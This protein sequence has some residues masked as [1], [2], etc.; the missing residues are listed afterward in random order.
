MGIQHLLEWVALRTRGR[1][2]RSGSRLYRRQQSSLAASLRA[3]RAF[4]EPLEDRCVLAAI[5]ETPLIN[6]SIDISGGD[7]VIADL[8][9]IDSTLTIQSDT[10]NNVFVISDPN[11]LLGFATSIEGAT[12]HGSGA[13]TV[14]F[15]A[16]TGSQIIVDTLD[17]NDTLTVDF[18][19]GHFSPDITY[20]G[21]D[22][23]DPHG[24]D[25][26]LQGGGTFALA[27]Y[28]FANAT[29]GSIDISGNATITYSG[30]EQPI[31]STIDATDITLNYSAAAETITVVEA[32]HLTF[33]E[34]KDDVRFG[35]RSVTTSPDGKH[36]YIASLSSNAVSILSRDAVTGRLTFVEAIQDGD[37]GIDGLED[38]R[39]VT[40]SP[41]GNHV[42]FVSDYFRS[43]DDGAVTVFS[44]DAV[45][46]RLTFV[47]TIKDSDA[48]IDG[49]GGAYDVT[50]SPDGSHVY[51]AS[52]SDAAVVVFSRD[53]ETGRLAFVETIQDGDTGLDR[54][55]GAR[56]IT[57]SPDGKHVYLVSQF[58]GA[59]AVFS[60][61]AVTGRLTFVEAIK[62][63]DAGID[64][65]DGAKDVTSSPDG[66]HVYVASGF[67]DNAVS[68]FSRDAVTGRLEFVETIK[69]IERGID[70]LDGAYDVATSPDGKH[71]YIA[72]LS[73]DAMAVFSRDA[74]TGR[75]TLVE[76]I[77]ASDAGIDELDG[78]TTSPDG[79]DVYITSFS[80]AVAVFSRN[81]IVRQ[82]T[83]VTSTAGESLTF[84]NPDD[85]L[86][87][88]AG[89]TG[90]DTIHINS[91]DADHP[92]KIVVNGQGGD[93]QLTIDFSVGNFSSPI[94]YH[95]GDTA[96]SSGDNLVLQGG[97]T[98]ASAEYN[99]AN[100]T[101]GN[102]DIAGNAT[103]TYTGLEQPITSTINAT[104]VTLNYSAED[105]TI[106]VTDASV[107]GT[108]RLTFVETIKDSDAGIDGLGEAG[109]VTTSPDGKHVYI[110]SSSDN[111]VTVFSSDARTGL[112]TFVE[113]IK[114]SDAG[115][116][117]LNKA[118]GVA[119]SPDGKHVYIATNSENAVVVFGRDA[120]T[121]RLTFVE[122][123][124]DSEVGNGGGGN[125]GLTT[126]LDGKYVYVTS[127]LDET[128]A[129]FSRDAAT[130]RLTL[131]E[132]IKDG[133]AG[134]DGLDGAHGITTSPDEN[135]VYIA[136]GIADNA[137]TVF[138]RDAVT[139]RLTFVETIKDSDAGIDGL[140]HASGVT[141]SPD[142]KH[143][144]IASRFD[145]AVA[146]FSR[147]AGT[148]RLTFVET[149]RGIDGLDG[150]RGITAS[151]DGNHVYIASLSDNA[152]A[153]FS[154]D[155]A[156]GRLTLVE[157]IQDSDAG[158]DGLD[159]ARAITTSP[160][161]NL[162]YIASSTDGAVA[163]FRRDDGARNTVT[164]TAGQSVTSAN[165][166]GSL[167]INAGS[168]NDT[169][170]LTGIGHDLDL[171]QVADASLQGF[172][173]IDITGDGDNTLT[174]DASEVI[175]LSPTTD[176]LRVRHDVGDVVNYRGDW[177]V[178]LPQ[179]IDTQYVHILIQDGATIEVANT[180]A[181]QNPLLSLD[182]N[183]DRSVSPVDAL[184][185]INRLNTVGPAE[186]LT[187]T[188]IGN[189]TEFFYLDTNG[190]RFL[191]PIDVIRIVNFLNDTVSNQEGEYAVSQVASR[192]FDGTS[193]LSD[194]PVAGQ[195]D[196]SPTLHCSAKL[197]VGP[198]TAKEYLQPAQSR[199]KR[200][201]TGSEDEDL[202]IAVDAFFGDF[203]F[204]TL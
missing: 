56:G 50:T 53:T 55:S 186:L 102:I 46:G 6:S 51:I 82:Q 94:E 173:A 62:D 104:D 181:F 21:G 78:V 118:S 164:S 133:D 97:G 23:G 153:V 158:I 203:N 12:G 152:I 130:G 113:T 69:D 144:Y 185:V 131:V 88:N 43:R 30:L 66:K 44:R 161:G 86:T 127:W 116:D 92:D 157:T 191:A 103:I 141:T 166:S 67:P 114:D 154:R 84:V 33:V 59:V 19:L 112:L 145:D 95:G 167:T 15:A 200:L 4:F 9:G 199:M 5:V 57:T 119:T 172:E 108:G 8:Q 138:S 49:L 48:V 110:A 122:T 169:L 171:T 99:F 18:S 147:D 182:V 65:L 47:E 134:I 143:V 36:V 196:N 2:C 25:L 106:T 70:G 35:A 58:D 77:Q 178:E 168:G 136:S 132:T 197:T 179:I 27:E 176:I 159:G 79:N 142:G 28:N 42:Y 90:N 115:I 7:L 120:G 190:D 17:G 24:D 192:A 3:R 107:T 183:R 177:S 87:I 124:K 121:G 39:S 135:H 64:G 165:T 26:V 187:P 68:V 37:P 193:N 80:G 85:T 98:F 93:D 1:R 81:A 10:T 149:I 111:A 52:S 126:S 139:G 150:A 202:V 170:R 83:Q 74:A 45:T 11:N 100:A 162:V 160:D 75:L 194:I 61:D 22:T 198:A 29:D 63:T 71:V 117:G 188:S 34:T 125:R 41:D 40:T 128:V 184:I 180:V 140:W 31:T 175:N 91:L 151:R 32:R 105:E 163:V 13:V 72:S 146:V 96:E 148:G 101:G 204:D 155:A 60:R 156:T 76:T 14:P 73:D 20:N 89:D 109:G 201:V 189:P 16:V 123:I 195:H 137:V 174:L 38:V 129:V 54:L